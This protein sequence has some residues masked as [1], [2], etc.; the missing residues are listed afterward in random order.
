[1]ADFI[2]A[3]SDEQ[4]EQRMQMIKD[5]VD[6]LFSEK[7]YHEITLTTIAEKLDC[8]RANLYKYVSTKEEIFLELSSDKRDDYYDALLA[9]FPEGCGYSMEV[10]AEV[11]AGILNAHQDHLHYC[12]ILSTIIETNVS[13]DRLAA[14]KK[15]YYA[16]AYEI[17]AMLAS[18]LQMSQDTAYQMLLN[19]HYHAV[20]INSIGRWNPL[21]VEAL[22]K[23]NIIAPKINFRENMKEFILMNLKTFSKK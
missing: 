20:G 1:M 8:T 5:V 3:R 9:A 23:E 14:F 6:M 21:V 18:H 13:V 12:D 16:R 15:R 2:R 4:K 19:I 7:P 17:A 11:W 22:A 10:F